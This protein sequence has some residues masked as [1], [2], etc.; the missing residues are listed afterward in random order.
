MSSVEIF[1]IVL[2]LGAGYLVIWTLWK[3]EAGRTEAP[4]PRDSFFDA[5][6]PGKRW[7]E[8]L[9]VN[10]CATPEE[11]RAAYKLQMSRYHPDKLASLGEELRVVAERKAKEIDQA[12]QEGLAA[13]R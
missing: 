4:A 3:P 11:I 7:F 1:A 8:V 12:Y 2:G 6:Q 13:F 9:E 5:A 10:S